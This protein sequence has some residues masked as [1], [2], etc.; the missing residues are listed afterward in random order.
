MKLADMKMK[1]KF[2]QIGRT[3]SSQTCN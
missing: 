1:E 3:R 2:R